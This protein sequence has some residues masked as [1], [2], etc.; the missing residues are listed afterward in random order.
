MK[1]YGR[2]SARNI[3]ANAM[4]FGLTMTAGA[5]FPTLLHAQ[6]NARTLEEVVVTAQKR[7]QSLQDVP[8]T[9]NVL[10]AE[11]LRVST[12]T[13]VNQLSVMTPGIFINSDQTGRNTKIKI[14]GVG[15]DEASNIRPSIGFFY[16][17][18]PLMTQLQGGQSVASDL[19]L[20]DLTR[21]EILK[22]P[23]STLF[24]ESVSAGAIAFYT[25]RPLLNE[26]WNGKFSVNYGSHYL[27][28]YR[29]AVGGDL[30]SA[31]A[32]R[33]TAYDNR[34]DDQVKNTLDNSRRELGSNGF[35]A[36]V[37]YEPIESLQ[38][39]L[40]YNR[41]N[42]SQD[43]GA[44]DGLDIISYGA[45]TIAEAAN[46][47][48]TLTPPD[49]FDR[50]VQ[51]LFP[52]TENM[53]NE[54]VSLHIDYEI[55]AD[56]SLT[57][58]TA[59]QMNKDH[60]GGDALLGG[61]NASNGVTE[62]FYAQGDQKIDYT[63]SELRV[64]YDRDAVTSMF[65]VFVSRYDAPGTRGDFGFVFPGFVF[66]I[67]QYIELEKD[68]YSVFTH[69][70]WRFAPQWEL[71]AGA[72]YTVEEADGRNGLENF[73]GIYSEQPLDI[74]MFDKS[75][76]KEDAW[77]GTLKVLYNLDDDLVLYAGVDRG[78]RLGGINNLGE[79]NY[80]TEVALSVETGLKGYFL[81]RT[82]RV[83]ASIYRTDY[84]GYQAVLYNSEAFSFITQNADVIG[85]GVELEMNWIATNNLEVEFSALY[86][87][88]EYD[89]YL[90]ATCDNYQIAYGACP[91]NPVADAQD[92][93][94]VDLPA[95]PNWSANTAVQYQDEAM[96]GNLTWYVRGEYAYRGD[97]YAHSVGV[98][99]DPAQRIDAYG[100]FNAS[101][102][103]SFP[104]GW[105]FKLWGKNLA[106]EDYFTDIARQP[107]G[108]EPEYVQARIGWERSYGATVNYEF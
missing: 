78:F 105:S 82:L 23:Q 58:I 28:Q 85:Q 20:G 59:H 14:R 32:F 25:R 33:V 4:F 52:L 106:D 47:G 68:M 5:L 66:P 13:E 75:S 99:G 72:R 3:Q 42:S 81:D 36:Q 108:S 107:V 92:L 46:R 51:M 79:P 54:L 21:V 70:S 31:M 44:V 69:N 34:I 88:V 49:P 83:G 48:I 11:S 30:G 17:D 100:L 62:G 22:G 39:I 67:A 65:G 2:W 6:E 60:Y 43:G 18:I 10:T 73:Q 38:M 1:D 97:S 71:V 53:R 89:N 9:V 37:L 93:S 45:Q 61:Y 55:D 98:G 87:Q 64:N 8:S 27:R 103:F 80:D 56:W 63:T 57:S 74:S 102:G 41:R 84:D 96:G 40:E 16:N 19:D 15:P 91:N 101:L 24:G 104:S 76:S 86:N 77:G 12:I 95:S 26:G 90:G 7:E 29:G 50:K 35:S 94:G